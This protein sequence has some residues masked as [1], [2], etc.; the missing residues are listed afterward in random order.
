MALWRELIDSRI[1]ELHD[2]A[3]DKRLPM[4]DAVRKFVRPGMKLNMVALQSRPSALTFALCRAFAGKKPGFEYISSSIGAT[5]LA[6][7]HCGLFKKVI[8]SY[9]GESYPTPGPSKVVQ[10]A[11]ADGLDIE[12]WT[13][14]TISQRLLGGA[15]GVPW[16]PTRS[17]AG[18][19]IADEQK[20]RG[21]YIEVDDPARPGETFGLMKSYRPDISF[22]HAWAADKAG[23]AI[24]YPPYGENV[25]GPLAAREGVILTAD[26]IV[27]TDFIRDHAPLVRIP[28][29][30]VKSVSHAPYGCHPS[31]NFAQAIGEFKAYGNDYA[32]MRASRQTQGTRES[33]DAWVREWVL[34]VK[35]HEEYVRKLGKE[36]IE[37]LHK[38]GAADG[39]RAELEKFAN[40][41]DTERPASPIE[42]M[43]VHASRVV[44]TRMQAKGLKTVLSGVGQATLMAWLA[45][46]A[47]R[48]QG[49]E[50]T[51]MA[52]TGIYGH[53]PRP[54]DPF[55]FNFFNLHTTTVLTDIFETLGLH[56][57]GAA[58]QCL[59][60][61][62][63]G[64]VDR[65]GNVNST[66]SADGSFI[67]GSGGANDIATAAVES[68]VVAQQRLQT[69]VD[70]CEY[71]TSPGK[72]ITC[73]VSTMGR[74]EK[75]GG[76]E[77]VLTGYFGMEGLAREEA[78][79]EIKE[80]CGW[81]LQVADDV[82]ALPAATAEE[83]ALLRMFDPERFFLG[84]PAE[85]V[86]AAV[87]AK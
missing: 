40:D 14:L 45:A 7:L 87:P 55:V 16:F 70:K 81:E 53:D 82:E 4:A 31:G 80:R 49:V 10:R 57:G 62:G 73:C 1:A 52:E 18:S 38:I 56:T 69:F 84:K 8:V 60:T 5:A 42:N 85:T 22:V 23:N 41:L 26:H 19:S 28:A 48:K 15:M 74:F 27:D 30:I 21:N 17:L 3:T 11:I 86:Q 65:F 58:N 36:R 2:D 75:R 64:E 47:L 54:A 76:D 71:I 12:N 63:A 37:Y 9:A 61:F 46:H 66:K 6:T 44:A 83:L 51:M 29:A 59:G 68:V 43:I 25:Y 79:R 72:R 20:A 50:I 35:D 13:M 78:V 34:G 77:F 67:V 39:W 24:C 33:Y 32:F